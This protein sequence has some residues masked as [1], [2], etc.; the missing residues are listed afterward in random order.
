MPDATIHGHVGRPTLK[1]FAALAKN[2]V[3]R[4]FRAKC[5]VSRR[6]LSTVVNGEF[7]FDILKYCRLFHILNTLLG[8]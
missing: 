2:K 4:K 8:K 1:V 3:A 5:Y 6:C 7:L